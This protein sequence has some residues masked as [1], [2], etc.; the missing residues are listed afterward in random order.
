[1][2]S[3]LARHKDIFIQMDEE[4]L[5]AVEDAMTPLERI[6]YRF[7]TP[8]MKGRLLKRIADE[9][10]VDLFPKLK[11]VFPEHGLHLDLD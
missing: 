7:G 8:K 9:I 2:G 5:R 4:A 1:M 11:V 3:K 6:I 10:M